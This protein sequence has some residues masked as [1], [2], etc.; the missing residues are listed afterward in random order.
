MFS[1]HYKYTAMPQGSALKD[2]SYQCLCCCQNFLV[3]LKIAARIKKQLP[4]GL[5]GSSISKNSVKLSG[6]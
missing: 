3:F 2:L 5:L 1:G 6:K 4:R